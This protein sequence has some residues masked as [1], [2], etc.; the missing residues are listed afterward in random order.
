MKIG[1]IALKGND[2]SKEDVVW[3]AWPP[4]LDLYF[5]ENAVAPNGDRY[6]VDRESYR[7]LPPVE[8]ETKRPDIIAIKL[9]SIQHTP[10]MPPTSVDRDVLW[11]ECKAPDMQPPNNWQ[12]VMSEIIERLS[13]A[14]PDRKVYFILAVGLKWMPFVWDPPRVGQALVNPQGGPVR[15]RKAN[16]STW[17]PCHHVY[18]IPMP[19]QR[20]VDA[21]LCVDTSRAFTLDCWSRNQDGTR[22]YDSELQFLE[23]IF[24]H[25]QAVAFPGANPPEFG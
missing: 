2:Y 23:S 16:N 10:N 12:K 8:P 21:Q 15:I 5:H 17:P 6:C 13:I 22:K 19:G 7:G 11:I 3:H 24:A 4:I 18:A 20:H 9:S 14:H 1:K 25:L